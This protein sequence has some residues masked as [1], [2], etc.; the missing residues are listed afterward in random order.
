ML[1]L[2]YF[3]DTKKSDQGEDNHPGHFM[4]VYRSEATVPIQPDYITRLLGCWNGHAYLDVGFVG[5]TLINYTCGYGERL[6]TQ[7]RITPD[8]V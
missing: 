4:E 6:R 8:F 3:L 5:E 7:V 1:F 2:S